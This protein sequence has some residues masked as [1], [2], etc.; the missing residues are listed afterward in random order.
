MLLDN[1]RKVAVRRD[2]PELIEPEEE[3]DDDEDDKDAALEDDACR[4]LDN[5]ANYEGRFEP[6]LFGV[7]AAQGRVGRA[8]SRGDGPRGG[9]VCVMCGRLGAAKCSWWKAC[10][11]CATT[12]HTCGAVCQSATTGHAT[13]SRKAPPGRLARCIRVAGL[14]ASLPRGRDWAFS[15]KE[16]T[17]TAH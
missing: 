9:R 17:R 1:D 5:A 6:E 15:P 13:A 14:V 11:A 12:G 8:R 16:Q 2:A 3:S 4:A 7:M 10:G